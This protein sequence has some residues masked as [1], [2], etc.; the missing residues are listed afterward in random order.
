MGTLIHTRDERLFRCIAKEVNR[1]AGMF[2]RYFVLCTT[3]S[4]IDPLY[5]EFE[6]ESYNYGRSE[7]ERVNGIRMPCFTGKPDRV[8]SASEEG[9]RTTWDAQLWIAKCDWDDLVEG[10]KPKIGD[11]V[12]A[13]DKYYD[14]TYAGR[15]GIMD[16]E[17]SVYTMFRLD[18][19][20]NDKYDA[21][22]R[23]K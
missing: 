23:V 13:W 19:R 11:V 16:D 4:Q 1:L 22:R 10:V 15:A 6:S 20:K 14:V 9:K 12:L 2:C 3:T 17:R 18:L 8:V 7:E 5:N 21:H